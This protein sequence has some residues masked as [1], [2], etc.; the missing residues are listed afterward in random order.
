MEKTKITER[1]EKN[2]EEEDGIKEKQGCNRF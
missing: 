1:G 2:G